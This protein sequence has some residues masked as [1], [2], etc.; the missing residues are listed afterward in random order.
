MKTTIATKKRGRPIGSKT[1]PKRKPAQRRQRHQQQPQQQ[2]PP[3][4]QPA[5]APEP[6]PQ[7]QTTT[8]ILLA[9]LLPESA[10]SSFSTDRVEDQ[11]EQFEVIAKT[12]PDVIGG[13]DANLEGGAP[14]LIADPGTQP[15]ALV[16]AEGMVLINER[17]MRYYMNFGFAQI[18]RVTKDER[19]KL[20]NDELDAAAPVTVDLVAKWM[21]SLLTTSA[22]KEEIAF[23]IVMF[24]IVGPRLQMPK[25]P[26]NT[27][28]MGTRE[29]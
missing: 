19:W 2:Q 18:A 27:D 12:V 3:A 26:T 21:P 1:N 6:A 28:G 25:K 16:N 23:A 9:P 22:Y 24:G 10:N 20:E 15:D 4:P 11:I 13:S 14:D 5:V 7:Q 8:E 29:S 17:A